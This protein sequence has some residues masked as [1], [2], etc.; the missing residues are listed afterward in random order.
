MSVRR[1][2][3]A[4]VV[5]AGGAADERRAQALVDELTAQGIQTSYAGEQSCAL[6]IATRAAGEQADA[7]EIC[8]A[9]GAR[10]VL[11]LRELL[12]ELIELG[13]RDISIVV[14]RS[15]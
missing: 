10:G 15:R 8:L 7:V 2:R 11:L 14:H 3:K 5:L 12:R 13:R 6:T 1:P 4:L 9:S